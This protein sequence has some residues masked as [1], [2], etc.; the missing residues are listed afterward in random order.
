MRLDLK[1]KVSELDEI[2]CI[3][4]LEITGPLAAETKVVNAT[5][6][7]ATKMAK[8]T[9]AMLERKKYAG[10]VSKRGRS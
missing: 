7:K 9:R 5:N 1:W 3:P 4:L 10:Q 8:L 6:T 2:L